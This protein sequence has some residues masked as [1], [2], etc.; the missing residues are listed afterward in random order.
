MAICSRWRVSSREST[1]LVM[2][3][4][5]LRN[6]IGKP[7]ESVCRMRISSETRMCDG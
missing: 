4:A 6:T 5:T 3:A 1:A 7:M 2:N